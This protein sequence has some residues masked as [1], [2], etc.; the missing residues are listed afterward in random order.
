MRIGML[1]LANQLF[2]IYFRIK[3]TNLCDPLIRT[4]EKMPNSAYTAVVNLFSLAHQVTYKYFVG[5]IALFESEYKKADENLSYAFHHCHNKF[6]SNARMILVFLVPV[7]MLFGYIPKRATLEQYN[8]MH[9]YQLACALKKGNITKYNE[10]IK[11]HEQFFV[12]YGI[13]LI[14]LKLKKIV[15]RNLFKQVCI[16]SVFVFLCV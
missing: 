12:E 6:H 10:V 9:F 7:K 16:K 3:K 14:V 5:R 15:Y 13:Y 11:C 2:K 1:Y 4:I 8:L